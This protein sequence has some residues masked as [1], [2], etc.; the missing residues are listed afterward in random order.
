MALNEACQL[1]IEQEIDSGLK[2][3]E[4]PYAISQLIAKEVEK[5]FEVK[6]KPETIRS[7]VRR[8]VRSNDQPSK[9]SKKQTKPETKL[10]LEIMAKEIAAGEVSDDDAKTVGDSLAKAITN[11]KAAPRVG[12]RVATAV[13][14]SHRKEVKKPKPEPDNFQRLWKHVLA[15][16]EGLTFWADETMKPTTKDEANAVKGI[17]EAA[18]TIITQFARLGFDVVGTYETFVAPK[19]QN[20]ERKKDHLIVLLKE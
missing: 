2:R 9:P 11:G 4:T 10:Q 15:V 16:A 8:Q 3:G 12:S 20:N 19:E 18:Q 5:L 17:L 6:M 13:R 1:W 14:K 7:R